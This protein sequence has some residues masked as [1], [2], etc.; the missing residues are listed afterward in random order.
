MRPP[1]SSVVRLDTSVRQRPS[2]PSSRR[3]W[4]PHDVWWSASGRRDL[5][6]TSGDGAVDCERARAHARR[7]PG[8]GA[9]MQREL[10]PRGSIRDENDI[11]DELDCWCGEKKR[12]RSVAPRS[13]RDLKKIQSLQMVAIRAPAAILRARALKTCTQGARQTWR[14]RWIHIRRPYKLRSRNS[15]VTV[16]TSSLSSVFCWTHQFRRPNSYSAS[17]QP[18][19]TIPFHTDPI[20]TSVAT[21]R[22]IG[23]QP[24]LR[25][26]EVWYG[27]RVLL[28]GRMGRVDDEP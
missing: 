10:S 24:V 17:P 21:L 25:Q 26:V 7:Y 9:Y 6:I 20:P 12:G 4:C 2:Q 5:S 14:A 23:L 8:L 15:P 28:P 19:P 11:D 3:T 13:V 1:D 22:S 16:R 27:R 18:L